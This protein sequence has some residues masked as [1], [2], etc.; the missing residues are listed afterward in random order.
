MSIF[1]SPYRGIEMLTDVL[2]HSG[3]N[4]DT[5]QDWCQEVC[6]APWGPGDPARKA[7]RA[8]RART[9]TDAIAKSSALL[10]R[11]PGLPSPA[12]P[13]GWPDGNFQLGFWRPKRCQWGPFRIRT[14]R[15]RHQNRPRRPRKN[16]GLTQN[17]QPF[18]KSPPPFTLRD[19]TGRSPPSQSH[20]SYI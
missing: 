18:W 11:A 13:W 2:A 8:R 7:R 4:F 16:V 5:S 14:G 6:G 17:P 10:G 3:Q 12:G 20:A 9:T 1:E 15:C 19:G